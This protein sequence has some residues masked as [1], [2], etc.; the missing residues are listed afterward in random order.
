MNPFNIPVR[1]FQVPTHEKQLVRRED[2]EKMERAQD[3]LEQARS[4]ANALVEQAQQELEQARCEISEMHQRA[5]QE[6]KQSATLLAEQAKE[7]AISKTV[8]WIVD[9]VSIE[10]V[11]AKQMSER[12]RSLVTVAIREYS[13]T[14][15]VSEILVRRLTKPIDEQ[16]AKGNV[17]LKVHPNAMHSIR[18]TLG[19]NDGLTVVA[20]D[21]LSDKQARLET[22]LVRVDIDLDQHLQL[23]LDKLLCEPEALAV[24]EQ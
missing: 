21:G 7:Q 12:I 11:I 24:G 13:A 17:T 16:L 15:D 9:E 2:L 23:I 10:Q 5:A 6:A 18:G 22:A 1:Q 14:Q 19:E 4:R 3:I 20:D 8:D